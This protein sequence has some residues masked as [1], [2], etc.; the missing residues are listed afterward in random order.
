MFGRGSARGPAPLLRGYSLRVSPSF[1]PSC[2]RA[3]VATYS[4]S[5]DGAYLPSSAVAPLYIYETCDKY[6]ELGKWSG[7]GILGSVFGGWSGSGSSGEG[8][9]PS[10]GNGYGGKYPDGHYYPPGERACACMCRERGGGA[11]G[12]LACWVG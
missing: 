10:Y 8:G 1:P 2:C 3:V 7:A 12:W 9:Y 11:C 6:A 5:A 4:G